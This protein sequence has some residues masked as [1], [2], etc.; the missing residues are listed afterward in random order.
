MDFSNIADKVTKA[1]YSSILLGNL[2]A[3]Y[4]KYLQHRYLFQEWHITPINFRPYAI[5]IV[6]YLNKQPKKKVVEIGCGLGEIIG[7]CKDCE[8]QGLDLDEEVIKAAGRLYRNT[9]FC[10][11]TFENIVDEQIDYLITVNFIHAI[12]PEELKRDYQYLC[13]NNDIKNIVLDITDSPNYQYV[14]NVRY[15][16]DGLGYMVKKRLKRYQVINGTR[17]IYILEKAK[18]NDCLNANIC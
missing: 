9:H 6:D 5:G 7:N 17:W 13:E 11:G 15:L 2:K 14:H 18:G 10:V 3:I 4:F 8:R 1:W 12:A 16:F